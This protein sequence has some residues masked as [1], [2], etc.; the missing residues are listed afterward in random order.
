MSTLL[1]IRATGSR[2]VNTVMLGQLPLTVA[3]LTGNTDIVDVLLE[4]RADLHIQNEEYDTVFHSLVK[5]AATYPEKVVTVIQMMRH[6][7]QELENKNR[8]EKNTLDHSGN[9]MHRHTHSLV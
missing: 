3:A 8:I 5:N 9:D 1:H 6:L 2:F 7:N 4:F